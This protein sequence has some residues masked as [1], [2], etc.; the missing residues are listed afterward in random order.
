[1]VGRYTSGTTV[2][3]PLRCSCIA[4]G[5]AD[6]SRN[7][8]RLKLTRLSCLL[9]GALATYRMP[10]SSAKVVTRL[11]PNRVW[12]RP[13]IQQT[14]L[15]Y[16]RSRWLKISLAASLMCVTAYVLDP[17]VVH[18]H[19]GTWLGY[20][21]GTVGALLIVWL[22]LFGVR[23][24]AYRASATTVQ[25]WLSAHVY[26]GTALILIVTLHTGF[27]FGWNTHTL[28]YALMMGVVFSGFVG[29][30]FYLRFPSFLGQAL[31]GET[32]EQHLQ[33][34]GGIDAES[35]TIAVNLPDDI[36]QLLLQSAHGALYEN[37]LQRF[38]G[39]NPSCRTRL[40]VDRLAS[41]VQR[42]PPA[43]LAAGQQ[44]YAL[45][46][47]KLARLDR[48]RDYLR[49][50]AWLDV[51]LVLHVPMAF[52]LLAALIGHIVSVFFFW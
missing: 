43:Q 24:R 26:L 8:D 22:M 21:L 25:G 35:R 33:V 30:Y 47:Q 6:W 28:A 20:T 18:P 10:G 49:L 3:V 27:Q 9:R 17:S 16:R 38:R 19:G 5:F 45:Q 46:L 41:V 15:S 52:G 14:L 1:M 31:R 39:R 11:G 23:K 7:M 12:G 44:L 4:G 13:M 32:L 50:K 40:L 34:V 37:L 51:W 42:L 48:L 2:V 29:T 36:N